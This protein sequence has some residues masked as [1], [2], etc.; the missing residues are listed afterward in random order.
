MTEETTNFRL[1][2]LGDLQIIREPGA[3]LPR[4]TNARACH[5]LAM[6]A[7]KTAHDRQELVD[8]FWEGETLH[9]ADDV[10]AKRV[11]NKLDRVFTEVRLTL[12]IAG[13]EILESD[14]GV[15]RWVEGAPYRLTSDLAEFQALARSD[16]PDDWRAALALVRGRVAQ[17]LPQERTLTDSFGAARQQ[18]QEEITEL[19]RRLDPDA[20]D[21]ALNHR[22]QNVLDGRYRED[23]LR[24]QAAQ[25]EGAADLPSPADH[26]TIALGGKVE[27]PPSSAPE[28][29]E[30]SRSTRRRVRRRWLIAGVVTGAVFGLG[31]AAWAVWPASS[32]KVSTPPFGAVVDART[33]QVAHYVA[34]HTHSKSPPLEIEVLIWVCDISIRRPCEY[35]KT[36]Q[37]LTAHRGDILEV[38]IRLYDEAETPLVGVSV[39]WFYT[40]ET[41][42]LFSTNQVFNVGVTAFDRP[43]GK[44]I[45]EE[46]ANSVYVRMLPTGEGIT[47]MPLYITGSTVL[48]S[49]SPHFYHPLPDGIMR[50]QTLLTKSSS[51][52]RIW[53]TNLGA[54]ASSCAECRYQAT[55]FIHLRVQML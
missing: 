35:P 24:Q 1:N 48:T 27:P 7:F 54:S 17:H 8:I 14:R 15:I 29:H 34:S 9:H 11:A 36:S 47:Y 46:A 3:A 42:P 22:V 19:L 32:H 38:W 49:L 52:K 18:Q 23:Y 37:P 43:N 41:P 16:R 5:F 6:L 2:V 21:D 25:P 28:P 39:G 40:Y 12:G 45:S 51:M 31:L 55:R 13:K 30:A 33:G 4:P 50:R 26:P 10:E 53:L 20:A 44:P